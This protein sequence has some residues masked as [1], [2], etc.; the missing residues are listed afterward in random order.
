MSVQDLSIW[1]DRRTIDNAW[2]RGGYLSFQQ[3]ERPLTVAKPPRPSPAL[4]PSQVPANWAVLQIL[5]QSRIFIV[6]NGR[7]W[8]RMTRY[9]TAL[10]LVEISRLNGVVGK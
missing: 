10:E 3:F 4:P 1:H 2:G 8:R 7:A 5:A 9:A 6:Q